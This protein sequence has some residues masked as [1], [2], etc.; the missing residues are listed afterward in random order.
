MQETESWL[1]WFFTLPGVSN[2]VT[3][4][5]N[6]VTYKVHTWTL[7]LSHKSKHTHTQV[8][9]PH[10]VLSKFLIFCWLAFITT[11]GY[12]MHSIWIG[13]TFVLLIFKQMILS[14]LVFKIN[15]QSCWRLGLLNSVL[16]LY[17]LI[18]CDLPPCFLKKP[19]LLRIMH[20]HV[21]TYVALQQCQGQE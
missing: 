5:H 21:S 2:V 4:W 10:D 12:M 18:P 16:I 6:V 9:T 7:Q 13:H 1:I 3:L 8:H 11:L 17:P 20:F 15:W 19:R 14:S